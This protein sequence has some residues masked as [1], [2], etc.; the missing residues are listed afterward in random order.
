V[1]LRKDYLSITT[2][3]IWI[4]ALALSAV[5]FVF[6]HGGKTERVLFFPRYNE[7]ELVGESRILPGKATVED[8]IELLVSE[9]VLG[10]ME[11]H[12]DRVLPKTTDVQSVILREDTLYIDFSLDPVLKKGTSV[13]SFQEQIEAVQRSVR[14]N[15]P[16]IEEIIVSFR[17]ETPELSDLR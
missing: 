11:I 3:G 7:S 15:F 1:S 16:S 2:L 14:F 8:D 4:I 17:G 10:P 9:I 6:I 13:L 12:H 5:L